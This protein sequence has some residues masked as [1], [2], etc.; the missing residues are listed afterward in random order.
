MTGKLSILSVLLL[1]AVLIGLFLGSTSLN[2]SHWTA[3][4]A[5]ILWDIRLP[6]VILALFVGIALSSS[7]AAF[8]ALLRNPL[9]DPFILGVS[10]G[11]ALGNVL[12]ISLGFSFSGAQLAAF[13]TAVAVMLGIYALSREHGRLSNTTLLL[14]GAVANAFFFSIIM[15]VFHFLAPREAH[16]VLFLLMGSLEVDSWAAVLTTGTLIGIGFIALVA[17]SAPL[18]LLILGEDTATSL[19]LRVEPYRRALFFAASLMVGAAVSVSGLIG[20]VGL[21]IPHMM[22]L[23]VG[24]DHRILIPASGLAG[25]SFLILADSLA[26]SLLAHSAL[27]TEL[28][29]GVITALIGVPCF[30]IL[31]KRKS[32]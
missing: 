21:F 29:V 14:S 27:Q 2:W 8:Q 10:G 12:A 5:L 22:R 13:G 17:L 25:A 31:L 20:F 26:R 19:G 23:L 16:Q 11:A 6:R 28:P 30:F 4:D 24:T 3:Q 9:A 1:A 32:L 18:N 7:G 15:F